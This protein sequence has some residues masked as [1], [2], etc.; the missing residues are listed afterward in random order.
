MPC[1][2]RVVIVC[3]LGPDKALKTVVARRPIGTERLRHEGALARLPWREELAQQKCI[4]AYK[5]HPTKKS[6]ELA[7]GDGAELAKGK[8]DSSNTT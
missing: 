6:I 7:G 5:S 4:L 3:G 8:L 1:L 2:A